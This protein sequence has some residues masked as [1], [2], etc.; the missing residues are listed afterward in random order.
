MHAKYVCLVSLGALVAIKFLVGGLE[1]L[2]HLKVSL[3]IR[4]RLLLQD[5][6]LVKVLINVTLNIC[7]LLWWILWVRL[8]CDLVIVT[9]LDKLAEVKGFIDIMGILLSELRQTLLEVRMEV[10]WVDKQSLCQDVLSQLVLWDHTL[11]G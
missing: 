6:G 9:T 10:T 11:D 8:E 3:G 4:V 7:K 1:N 5:L 2:G